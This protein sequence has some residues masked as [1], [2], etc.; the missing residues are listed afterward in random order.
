MPTVVGTT[1]LRTDG[2]GLPKINR[3]IGARTRMGDGYGKI[4]LAGPGFQMSHGAG[5]RI[6]MAR[7]FKETRDG[8]GP[9]ARTAST[10]RR[11]W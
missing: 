7:G 4:H 8:I 3:K 1:M 11:V 2:F 9:Q 5:R 10:G 6:T